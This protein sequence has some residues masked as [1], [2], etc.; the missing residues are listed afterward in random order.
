MSNKVTFSKEKVCI[1]GS[2]NA[3]RWL[4]LHRADMSNDHVYID[5]ISSSD[6]T[7]MVILVDSLDP[8]R[9]PPS[10]TVSSDLSTLYKGR[11]NKGLRGLG[12]KIS[13]G[14]SKSTAIVYVRADADADVDNVNPSD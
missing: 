13:T 12:Y 2:S 14:E 1:E 5:Y 9:R 10:I 7:D 8:Q 4:L 11:I 6:F 3:V